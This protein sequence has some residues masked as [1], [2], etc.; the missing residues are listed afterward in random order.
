MGDYTDELPEFEYLAKLRAALPE[1]AVEECVEGTG[2]VTT[3]GAHVTA[4]GD[5][6]GDVPSGP[7]ASDPEEPGGAPTLGAAAHNFGMGSSGAAGGAAAPS[8]PNCRT[9]NVEVTIGDETVEVS[10]FDISVVNNL[11][12]DVERAVNEIRR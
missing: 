3:P 8:H 9:S 2:P 1:W 4:S 7:S 10:D 5:L 11:K 12:R 6:H